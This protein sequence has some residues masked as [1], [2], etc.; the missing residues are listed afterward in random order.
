VNWVFDLPGRAI[1]AGG[2]VIGVNPPPPPSGP[3]S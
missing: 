1:E 3:S 2:R